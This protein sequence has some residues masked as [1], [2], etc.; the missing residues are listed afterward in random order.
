MIRYIE[1]S[2]IHPHPDNPRKDLGD[3]EELVESIKTSGI[4]QNLTIVPQQEG[5]GYR[6]VIGHRRLAAAKLA[7]LT[8]VP[9][10]ISDMDY[11]TQIAT[12]L[13]E[14]IQRSDLTVYEQAQGFQM[15]LDLGETVAEISE[16]TGFSETTVRRRMK[17]LEL[18]QDKLKE[19]VGRGATLM[20]YVELEKIENIELRN[21]VLEKV[22]TSDFDW[23]LKRAIEDEKRKKKFN[24]ILEEVKKFATE[25]E[26]TTGLNYKDA[27]YGRPSDKFEVPEDID[28]VE[29][30]YCVRHD[31]IIL[32]Y[33]DQ[34]SDEKDDKEEEKKARLEEEKLKKLEE[35]SKTAYELRQE[36]I[37]N[38]SNIKAKEHIAIIIEELITQLSRTYIRSSYKNISDLLNLTTNEE[39]IKREDMAS[40]INRKPE[41]S[42]LIA[43]YSVM[44][45]KYLNYYSNWDGTYSASERLDQVY[46]FLTKIGYEMSEEEKQLQDGTH[47]LFADTE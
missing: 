8:E 29:Y 35:L 26:D 28:E 36:F 16:K 9:C 11:K 14:N 45:E 17:L 5:I 21:E 13:L 40:E 2:K 4:L 47:E 6:V 43:T 42:L 32:Y 20:D 19:S 3:L 30:F 37:K 7:G 41:L 10:A 31:Y 18:D 38:Y 15:M 34:T 44:D 23:A 25:I 39:D 1:I 12:M 22:G 46:D 24:E 33:K 27:Y